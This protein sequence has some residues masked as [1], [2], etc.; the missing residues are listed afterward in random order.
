MKNFL[1]LAASVFA[2]SGFA[3]DK[4]PDGKYEGMGHYSL[5]NGQKAGYQEK[6]EIKNNVIRSEIQV[7]AGGASTT[8]VYETKIDFKANGFLAVTVTDK[9]KNV[10]FPGSGYCASV[11]CHVQSDNGKFEMTFVIA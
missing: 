3:I 6:L 2:V 5:E 9:V 4:L 8:E 7:S 11:W 10:T 1:C